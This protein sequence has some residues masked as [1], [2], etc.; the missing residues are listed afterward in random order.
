MLVSV[1]LRK[2]RLPNVRNP[3][4]NGGF[5]TKNI[6]FYKMMGRRMRGIVKIP[7]YKVADTVE[8]VGRHG[9]EPWTKGL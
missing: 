7:S 4:E 8:M 9:L 6:V 5:M 1:L 3:V 2:V